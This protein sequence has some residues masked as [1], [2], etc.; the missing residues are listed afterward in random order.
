MSVHHI[1]LWRF[2]VDQN[3]PDL[4]VKIE[5]TAEMLRECGTATAGIER[6]EVGI[7]TSGNADNAQLTLVSKFIDDDALK[8]Y[9]AHPKHKALS[10]QLKTLVR[11]R[12]VCDYSD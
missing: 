5:Q 8:T 2:P 7:D 11:E 3:G 6:F 12:L 1:V 4:A 9:I 10:A